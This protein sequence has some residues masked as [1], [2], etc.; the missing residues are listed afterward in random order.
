MN[1]IKYV[2]VY[3][4]PIRGN[5]SLYDQERWQITNSQLGLYPSLVGNWLFIPRNQDYDEQH[6]KR[7]SIEQNPNSIKPGKSLKQAELYQNVI[8]WMSND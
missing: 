2:V 6:Q 1:K 3:L 5:R 4:K 8:K 7:Y